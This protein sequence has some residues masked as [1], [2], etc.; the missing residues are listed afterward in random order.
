MS[1][2][3]KKPQAEEF[4]GRHMLFVML[5][6]FGVIIFV[7]ITMAVLAGRSWTGLVV[8][9]SYVA[10]QHFNRE[11][12][13]ARQQHQRGWK[14]SLQYAAG[15]LTFRVH[16]RHGAPLALQNMTLEL[17]RPAFEHADRQVLLRYSGNGTYRSD[18]K[19]APGIWSLRITGSAKRQPY[20]RDSRLSVAPD[21][22]TGQEQS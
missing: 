13:A 1:N 11:L 6:F 18:I 19:L 7:N 16:D 3:A 17:G 12:E 21:G 5:A 15:V 4:T 14:T 20:R 22:L 2:F 9:N 8:Q 10:N